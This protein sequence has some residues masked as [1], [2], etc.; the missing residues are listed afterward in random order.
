MSARDQARPG[1]TTACDSSGRP[2]CSLA[3]CSVTATVASEEPSPTVSLPDQATPPQNRPSR[4]HGA[5]N[6]HAAET[7][8]RCSVTERRRTIGEAFPAGGQ[9]KG[10]RYSDSTIRIASCKTLADAV[11]ARAEVCA[12]CVTGSERLNLVPALKVK[13]DWLPS[14]IQSRGRPTPGLVL[15]GFN[16]RTMR[17]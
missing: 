17:R 6:L 9:L 4:R 13:R 15:L 10:Y 16:V 12:A 2:A 7:S 3:R 1:A 14:G 11:L 5:R 8:P